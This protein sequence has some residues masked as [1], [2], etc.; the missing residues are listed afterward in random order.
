MQDRV[1][2]VVLN[3]NGWKDTQM[4]LSSLR[5]LDYQNYEVIVVDNGSSD[6]SAARIGSDFSEVTIV[7]TGENRGFAGGCNL[8]IR[9]ALSHSADFVWL[10]NN[11][12]I[13]HPEALQRLM[14]KAQGDRRIAAVGSAIYYMEEPQHLQAWGGGHVNFWLGRSRHFLAP[15]PDDAVDF[16]TGASMLLSREA[17]GSVGL[18]DER[19]FMY[20]EDADFCFR[21]RNAKWK[22]AVAGDSKIWHKGSASV[23][24]NSVRLDT[25]F[26]ASAARFFRRHA[27]APFVPLLTGG[28][29]R[30]AKRALN[31]DWQRIRAVWAGITHERT[32]C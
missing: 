23:G 31:G 29:L 16:I 27:V 10:L 17:L 30:L 13:V 32:S 8:G 12:T 26:N 19:F 20:W 14:D 25:Y 3:W 11:D 4:C 28:G 15:V 22:L 5:Q 6:D 21:L 9:H 7:E 1:A 18:L 24:K 2:I